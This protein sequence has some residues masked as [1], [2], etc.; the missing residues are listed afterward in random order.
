MR[1]PHRASRDPFQRP[2]R[3]P[4]LLRRPLRLD[5]PDRGSLPGLHLRRHGRPRQH[6][7]WRSARSRATADL[8]TFFVGVEDI[9]RVDEGGHPAG[10][11]RRAGGHDGPRRQVRPDR[12]PAGARRRARAAARGVARPHARGTRRIGR[13]PA[14]APRTLADQLRGWSDEQLS[15]LLEARPD[16]AHA[17]RRTTPRSWRRG[18]WSRR[19]C[20]G[21]ST[22][23]TPWSWRC[24]RRSS[25]TPSPRLL[26]RPGQRPSSGP[27][28]GCGRSRWSGAPPTGPSSSCASCCACRRAAGRRGAPAC[29]ESSTLRRGRSSTTSPTPAPTAA[30]AAA[31]G[32]RPSWSRSGCSRTSTSATCGCPGRCAGLLDPRPAAASTSR[33][34]WP[35]PSARSRWSTGPPPAPRSSWYDAPSCSWTDGAPI[36]RRALKAGGLGVRDL[37]AAAALLHV[38]PDVAA[39]VIE[40]AAAAG[41][42]DQGM[43]DD[44]GRGLAADRRLRRLAG[45]LDRRER[46][47]T[48]ARA[49]LASPRLVSAIG[50]RIGD[51]P[52]NALSPDLPRSWLRRPPRRR[53][54]RAARTCR[55]DQALAPGT[56]VASLVPRLRW[57]R[58][59]RPLARLD[60]VGSPARRG[61][62]ARHHRAGRDVDR[63]GG[64]SST[65]RTRRR[66]RGAAA[67]PRR[68][69]AAPG[70]P[71]RDR[72]R[73]R[74]SRSSPASWPWSPTSSRAAGRPSTASPPRPY[75]APSTPA[76]RRPRCTTSS[77]RPRGRRSRSR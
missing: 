46:W 17:R 39:L 73:A 22:G 15:A 72:A 11:P 5:L 56:G 23:W 3:H 29:S 66:A 32:R 43:T 9:E 59:R 2:G 36:P 51:K 30:G 54:R 76:G 61:G 60:Q 18:W 53:A 58:P 77:P 31:P 65:V 71:D 40:T 68:P 55:P 41:L 67:G 75:D 74:S 13:M 69:R 48:L 62:A 12:R 4:Q 25:R 26:G 49:W 70:R 44:V 16:L 45:R 64:C 21:R 35:P 7:T 47:T 24:C 50:G 19:R 1:Q 63:S 20:C 28:D 14:T 42:L 34:R 8:V 33:R 52:V 10:R 57:R 27:C 37:R 38:E 6:S